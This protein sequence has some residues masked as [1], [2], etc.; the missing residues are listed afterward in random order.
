MHPCT[1]LYSISEKPVYGNVDGICKITGLESR[2]LNFEKWVK[3]TFTAFDTLKPGTIIS[4]EALLS[5][6]ELSPYIQ[7]LTGKDKPQNFRSY[8]HFIHN[9]K[10]HLLHKGQKQEMFDLLLQ[11]PQ[12]VCISDSG[13]KHL[14]YKNKPGM[15]QFEEAIIQPDISQ[16]IFLHSLI[17]ALAEALFTNE[18]IFTGLY[19]GYKILGYGASAWKEK[20]DI[21]KKHRG[22]AIFDLALFFSKI[23]YDDK[24]N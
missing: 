8:S 9:G 18:E 6:E 20:E 7:K 11:S 14:F 12:I 17:S 5:F 24:S 15:W 2:G 1:I 19:Q 23:K 22:S 3:K 10:W 16:F 4:N 21:L 13:Q